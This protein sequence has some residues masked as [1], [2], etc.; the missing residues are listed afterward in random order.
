[1]ENNTFLNLILVIPLQ[2]RLNVTLFFSLTS[3]DF[4][5]R[6]VSASRVFSCLGTCTR[7]K[8]LLYFSSLFFFSSCSSYFSSSLLSLPL[9]FACTC[10][11]FSPFPSLSLSL[12][13]SH[14]LILPVSLLLPSCLILLLPVCC[15]ATSFLF[16]TASFCI[17]FIVFPP[18]SCPSRPNPSL[19]CCFFHFPVSLML[20]Y[21]PLLF[22]VFFTPLLTHPPSCVLPCLT[23]PF[24]PSLSLSLLCFYLIHSLSCLST[25]Y[26]PLR[27]HP[28]LPPSLLLSSQRR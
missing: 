18:A 27:L 16:L 22:I 28:S 13:L 20:F 25:Y 8:I 4:S 24:S 21:L 23:P 26:L 3:L 5:L 14:S 1:M 11:S 12:P 19:P 10:L 9:S 17:S 2:H 6:V 7:R 15:C